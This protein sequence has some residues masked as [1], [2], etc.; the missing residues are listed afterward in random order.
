[1]KNLKRKLSAIV[2]STVFAS[3]QVSMASMDTGLGVGNGGA[4]INNISGGFVNM[5]TGYGSADLNFNGNSHVNWDTLNVNKGETLNFNAVGGASGLTILNTVNRGM[6]KIYGNINSNSGIKQLIISNPNG[7]LFDG[8]HFTTAGDL[9][10]TTKD[11]TNVNIDNLSQAEF[12]KLYQDGNLI[13]V[14]ILNGSDFNIGGEFSIVAPKIAAESSTIKAQTLKLI[15]ADGHDY[16]ALGATA[17]GANRAV[18]TLKAMNIDGDVYIT[19][20][21]GATN[22]VDGGVINGNLTTKTGGLAWFNRENNGN[23]LVINGNADITGA[24][25]HLFLRNVDVNG[26]LDMRNSGGFVDLGNAKVTGNANLTTTGM[27]EQGKYHHFVHVIGD[28]E[29]GGDL[30]IDSSQNI[31]I[32]GYDYDAQKLAD[33]KLTVG[34][35]LNAH[36]HNGHV[37]TTID[38]TA[39]KIVMKSDN[40]NVLTDGKAVLKADEYEFY[41]KGYIGGISDTTTDNGTKLSADEQIVNIMEN[42]VYI[43]NDIKSHT[44][45]KIAGGNVTHLETPGNAYIGSYGDMKLT[46]A[47]VGGDVN[48]T[49]YDSRIDITGDVHATNIN[50]GNETDTLKVDFPGRDYTLN[51]TNIRDQKVVTI[52]P[53]EEITYELANAP[54]AYNDPMGERAADTTYL[55]APDKPVGPEPPE[56]PVPP[57]PPTPEPDQPN[58]PTDDNVRLWNQV[59]DNGDINPVNTPV[60]F[61]ADLDDDEE[62]IGVRKNVDG[63]VTVVRAFPMF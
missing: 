4:V 15:T 31:H 55:I 3:M 61:A 19:N 8:A 60:A 40:Y 5:E 14:E 10:V 43:P 58:P 27:P 12:T 33:G 18:T 59:P 39:K 54:E 41:S 35:N 53:D 21:V 24:G 26:N 22:V 50:V 45:T 51:Y 20:E 63:S 1:M 13:P 32:G 48:L 57:V 42:Y 7:V 34:G 9:L 37:T 17:P 29:I 56:P 16:L 52:K 38:T 47:N 49:A 28:T 2:L 11:M 36:A 44:Y 25:E 46:G 62:D 23:R 6:S 30:N